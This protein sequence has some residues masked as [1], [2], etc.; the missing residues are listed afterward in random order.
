MPRLLVFLKSPSEPHAVSQQKANTPC[1][2]CD[3]DDLLF[4]RGKI[5]RSQ[6][7]CLH[8]SFSQSATAGT[9]L[10]TGLKAP[11]SGQLMRFYLAAMPTQ[12]RLFDLC[13]R[14]RAPAVDLKLPGHAVQLR[15]LLYPTT[16]VC[17]NFKPTP[18][19]PK[20]KRG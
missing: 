11:C 14:H 1:S 16:T 15:L 4:K 19:R 6:P 5:S 3:K 12:S 8:L 18:V 9:L 7:N 2:F 10:T 20:P 17:S 13:H